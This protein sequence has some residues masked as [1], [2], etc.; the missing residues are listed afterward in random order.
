[1]S[2]TS[3]SLQQSMR[4]ILVVTV[5]GMAAIFTA[6]PVQAAV[7]EELTITAQKREQNAQDV[8][9]AITAFS[10]DQ[11]RALGVEDSFDIAAFSPGVHISGNIAGQNTQFSIRGVTQNDF[12]DVIEAPN[13]V[14]LDEGYI[15]IAQGQ[16]FAVFDIDRVE[17]L[18][19]PQG[20]LYGRNATGGLVHF[21]SRKPTFDG[22][23]GFLDLTRGWFDTS[24]DAHQFRI[25]GAL[26]G[27]LSK[28]VAGRVAF[29]YNDQDAYL[30]NRYPLSAAGAA[31]G[32]G[33]GADMGDDETLGLRGT[34]L[35][36]PSEALSVTLS[37]NM[38]TTDVATGPYQSKPTIGIYNANGELTNTIDVAPDETRR[39][40][41]ADGTDCG[42]D[43]DDNGV[44]DDFFNNTT[45]AF[46]PDGLI[47]VGRPPGADFFGYIDPDGDD[48]KTS[49]DFAFED[50]GEI[51]TKGLMAKVEYDL[52]D[53]LKLT[54]VTDF[55]D[56]E[57]LIF[58]DVD[59]A[60]A[61]YL[62]NYAGVDA[63][64]FSQELRLNG[65][66]DNSR[67][68]LGLYYLNID[69]ES[70]NGLKI[71]QGGVAGLAQ[72]V[73]TDAKLETDS[74]SVF[75][76][77][78]F[79]LSDQL[80]LITGLRVMKEEK[81][82]VM[83]SGLYFGSIDP[84]TIHVGPKFLPPLPGGLSTAITT[85][86]SDN[87]WAGKLQLDYKPNDDLLLY[88]GVNRGVKAGSFNAPLLGSHIS[89]LFAQ[90]NDGIPYQEEE[91]LSYEGGFKV[92]LFEGTTRLNGSV[93]YYDYSDY[94]A[95]LFT[96]IGGVVINADADNVGIELELQTSPFDGFD[97]LLSFSWFDAT[98]KDVPLVIGSA[99]TRDV[100]PTY[101]PEL[102]ITAI[103]RY[104]WPMWKGMVNVLGDISYSDEFY[105]NLRNFDADLFDS[106]VMVNLGA[107]WTS[108]DERWYAGFRINNATDERAGIQGFN[109][110][111][112]C[113]CNEVSYRA[114]RW[115]GVNAKYSF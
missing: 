90:G 91:L 33:A 103:A 43:Q 110:A 55:K 112:G 63:Q 96:G 11:M 100:D 21:V 66:G 88:A 69:T 56:F 79:D 12:N 35:F 26:G 106:Y 85:D 72:D 61:N 87:L 105:Y 80:T 47:D 67:W 23:E 4:S 27:P 28:T 30:D 3:Y 45:G 86:S 70:D 6:L 77:Y 89:L 98:V 101:A 29:M 113:G 99:E 50:S 25:E 75:G 19:G 111:T 16:S 94:Q 54:S 83:D 24:A 41:C 51:D 84:R 14:Y 22:P 108:A 49:G 115:Y 92:T 73:G 17:I 15:A 53:S 7:L 37:A 65:E 34:L 9:I 52:N 71:S 95:F 93:F 44:T 109:I 64:T 39:T 76:Q 57:K 8:G 38:V 1:M 32:V 74:Y 18:K 31:P 46:G 62:A 104:E 13:A 68:V 59:S 10:G 114:P 58:I 42:S 20:T 82:F 48:F 40:I 102:Q 60:P 107:G 97:G 81:D 36:E 78:E 5:T 2:S